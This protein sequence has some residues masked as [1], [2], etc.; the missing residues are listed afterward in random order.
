MPGN[1]G[2]LTVVDQF[3][4]GLTGGYLV[5]N[6]AGRPLEFHCTVP[7][8]PEKIQKFLYGET[9]QPFLY[10]EKIAQ[11]L[12][13]RSKLSVFSILT[14][15]AAVLPVQPLVLTPVIYVFGVQTHRESLKAED[16]SV[17]EISEELNESLKTFGID[18]PHLRTRGSDWEEMSKVPRVPGFDTR[19]WQETRIGNRLIAVPETDEA[20]SQRLLAEISE[21]ARTIDLLE[22]FDRIHLALNKKKNATT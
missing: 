10:G 20:T 5:L 4:C 8:Q 3:P 14:N 12:I 7:L 22:P 13:Q 11:T 2:F 6:P 1:L 19:S 18:S 15:D 9:L 17:R 16:T 21:S